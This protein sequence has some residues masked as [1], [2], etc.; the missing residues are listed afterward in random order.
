MADQRYWWNQDQYLG[1]AVLMQAYRWMA[2][3]RV[4][5][6]DHRSLQLLIERI[7]IPRS[8]KSSCK[9]R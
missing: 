6:A 1:P 4:S 2:D 3:S 8:G 9:T 5:S 7:R